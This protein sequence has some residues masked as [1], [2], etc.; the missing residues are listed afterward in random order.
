MA[1][2]LLYLFFKKTNSMKSL[3][4]SITAAFIISSVFSFSQ[5]VDWQF[6]KMNGNECQVF[7][8]KGNSRIIVPANCFWLDGKPYSGSLQIVFKEYKDQVDFILGGLSMRYEI[9]GKLNTLQSGGMFEID[10]KSNTEFPKIL[11]FAPNKMITVKFAI[12]PNFDVVGLE[13]FYFDPI[14]KR[15]VKNTRFGDS[16]E[17]NQPIS[18]NENDLWQDDPLVAQFNN[19]TDWDGDS[20]DGGCYNI[21]IADRKNPNQFKDT[22]ICP[23]GYSPLDSKYQGYLS[24]QA[25]KT[26]QIDKMGLFNY[27]KIFNE[28]NNI[29]M[30]VNLKTNDGKE[31]KLT[32]KLYVVYKV[33][34]S[35]IYYYKDDLVKSFSLLPR[36]DI[37]IFSYNEDG[38]ISKV[39]DSFWK[40]FNPQ[41]MRGKTIDLPLETLK[42]ARLTKEEF[43]KVTG[44]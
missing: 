8:T 30:F 1:S 11:G 18:D 28:E 34:N 6:F 21:Q 3:K 41:V 16:N 10:I 17:S 12:D 31:F 39:P 27:D 7:I 23:Q 37:K 38:T 43:A 13:P 5:S 33:S 44:L 14:T 35:V 25:F 2:L 36:S 20:Q 40:N 42:L 24:D 22:L 15:W 26:M 32:G 9:D 4:L 29:P 19:N